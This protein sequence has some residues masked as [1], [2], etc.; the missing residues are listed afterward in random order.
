MVGDS[1]SAI[2]PLPS[3]SNSVDYTMQPTEDE[4]TDTNSS[5]SPLS[6][7]EISGDI[8]LI[9]AVAISM[10]IVVVVVFGL[11]KRKSK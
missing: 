3:P 4:L 1:L 11:V 5:T 8:V 7:F 10:S 9:I 2:P 6:I